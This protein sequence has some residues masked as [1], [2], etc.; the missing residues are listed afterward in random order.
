MQNDRYR[1]D[2]SWFIE[3]VDSLAVSVSVILHVF[4]SIL[5]GF[6]QLFLHWMQINLL[7]LTVLFDLLVGASSL[8]PTLPHPNHQQVEWLIG[9]FSSPPPVL[10]CPNHHPCLPLSQPPPPVIAHLNHH[11]PLS[12]PAP[13]TTPALPHP[14]PPLS[15]P[16]T[17]WT[18]CWWFF[19]TLPRH[20]WPW[21]SPAVL[22][23]Q[24]WSLKP[25]TSHYDLL[26]V[27]SCQPWPSNPFTTTTPLVLLPH[28]QLLSWWAFLT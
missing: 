12:L 25:P 11:H 20:H 21:P 1:N 10:A 2:F 15:Q 14:C 3:W 18:T 8:T 24:P 19:S 17:S 16:P 5:D 23:P 27:L 6:S 22:C 9:G 13:T 7:Y 4:C 26:V 28:N